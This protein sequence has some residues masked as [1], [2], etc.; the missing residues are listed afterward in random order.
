[1]L[2]LPELGLLEVFDGYLRFLLAHVSG[3][4][5]CQLTEMRCAAGQLCQLAQPCGVAVITEHTSALDLSGISLLSGDG[6]AAS[7][8][9][10]AWE[11]VGSRV[12]LPPSAPLPLGRL[13]A[14]NVCNECLRCAHSPCLTLSQRCLACLCRGLAQSE[15]L[16]ATVDPAYFDRP[17]T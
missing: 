17:V 2:A 3:C 7:G 15:P 14:V 13:A 9:A 8:P 5:V 11:D 6:E 1:L 12:P 10:Y 4:A 16:Y